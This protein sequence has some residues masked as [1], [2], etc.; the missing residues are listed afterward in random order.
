MLLVENLQNIEKQ[1]KKS[2]GLPL[3]RDKFCSRYRVLPL[4]Y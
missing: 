1:G 3:P 4:L 2:L